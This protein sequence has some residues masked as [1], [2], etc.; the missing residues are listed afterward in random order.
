[1]KQIDANKVLYG[2]HIG[3]HGYEQDGLINEVKRLC[4]DRGMNFVT[5]RMPK[6]L[7]APMKDDYLI[8][9]A[10][11]C[12]ENKLYFI[13]LYTLQHALTFDEGER[14][15]FLT[16]ELVKRIKEVAG[17]YYMGDMLGE[18]GSVWVGKL[19]GYYIPG[20]PPM[21]PQDAD[22]MQTA[23]DYFT[24]AVKD[25]VK[26]DRDMGIDKICVVEASMLVNQSLEAGIDF[27][28]LEL[29]P[30]EPERMIATF[31]GAM[32]AYSTGIWGAYFAHEWYAGL[33]HDDMLKRK[34]LELEY[35][36]AYLNGA[37][38]LCHESG[39]ELVTAYGRRFEYDSEVCTECR[40]FITKFGEYLNEDDRPE[41]QPITKLAFVQGNL[42]S[43]R[44][45]TN[46]CFVWG[47]YD[48]KEWGYH[49]PEWS[50]R[51]TDEVN[52]KSKW[53]DPYAYECEGKDFTGQVPYGTYDIIPAGASSEVMSKYDTLIYTGW[54]TMTDEQYENLKRFVENGGTLFITAAHLNT[55]PKRFGEFIPI[56]NGEVSELFGCRL[57][58]KTLSY[59]YGV[60]F[61]SESLVEGLKYPTNLS[62]FIDPNFSEGYIDYAEAEVT[63][64]TVITTIENSFRSVGNP[65]VPTIIEKK[66]GQGNVILMLSSCY[67]GRNSLYPIYSLVT[68]ALM[69]RGVCRADVR[70][71][72]PDTLRYAVYE[73]GSIYLLN[74]DYDTEYTVKVFHADTC[75]KI[76]VAPLELKHIRI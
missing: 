32:K 66:V 36:L 17:E 54:N 20:H 25:Y 58:G 33:F 28:L 43:F 76:T 69:H 45:G 9:W 24:A 46:G 74:T 52:R 21:L 12:A 8:N 7:K 64:G 40:E 18:L 72:G 37:K 22:N 48:R 51:I 5:I 1:M 34:R 41:G 67:P 65:G 75:K 60:K 29:M 15:S 13:Y 31:R 19:P 38:V 70:V 4:V 30:R 42:D 10:R 27:A 73:D 50:W 6:G 68:R 11:F 56:K 63:D 59:N 62:T 57:T 26:T 16:P 61:R 53:S 55:N 3:E 35:K 49:E 44:G 47:Q 23:K 39:D 14:R 71:C 2:A